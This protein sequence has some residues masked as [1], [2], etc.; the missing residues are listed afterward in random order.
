LN[1]I[2]TD[3]KDAATKDT[4]SISLTTLGILV[5]SNTQGQN[6][7]N[8][9]VRLMSFKIGDERYNLVQRENRIVKKKSGVLTVAGY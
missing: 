7:L 1:Y 4:D 6:Y 2:R 8:F 3:Y 9:Q 5:K